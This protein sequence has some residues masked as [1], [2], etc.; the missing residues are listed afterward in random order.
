M[1]GLSQLSNVKADRDLTSRVLVG[2]FTNDD[3]WHYAIAVLQFGVTS[4]KDLNA[5]AQTLTIEIEQGGSLIGSASTVDVPSGVTERIIFTKPFPT[6]DQDDSINVYVTS[7]NVND[8][9]VEVRC[10]ILDVGVSNCNVAFISEDST[11]ADNL[12]LDYDGTGYNKVNSTIGTTTTNADMRGTDSAALAANL[13]TTDG[14]VDTL[15]TNLS[16][17]DGKVDSI[18]VDTG[19]TLDGKIDGIIAGTSK[20]TPIDV[21]GLTFASAM[22]VLLAVLAG[23]SSVDGSTITFNKRDGSTAKIEVTVGSADGVRTTSTIQ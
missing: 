10:T 17:T 1:A 4:A 3:L 22:E 15:T 2:T 14:K 7:D 8:T 12:E 23:V 5:A 6:G 16:T 18:L 20:V 11:A 13:A 9:D 21:D 19:T